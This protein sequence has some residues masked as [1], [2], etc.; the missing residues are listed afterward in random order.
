MTEGLE[1]D[2]AAFTLRIEEAIRRRPHNWLWLHDRWKG[3][4]GGEQAS[5]A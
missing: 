2:T 1:E 5:A 3:A 4:P